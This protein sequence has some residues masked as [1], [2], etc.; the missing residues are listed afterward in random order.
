MGSVFKKLLII[1]TLII[2]FINLSCYQNPKVDYQK[3]KFLLLDDRLIENFKNAKLV[4]GTVKKN[5]ANPLFVEDKPWEKRF[6]NLYGNIIY[7]EDEN[8]YQCWYSP[9]IVDYSA[10]NMTLVERQQ[11]YDSPSDREM[12]ICYAYSKDGINW[13]KPE[14]GLVEFEGTKN[15]NLIG[16]GPHG[17]GVFRD[18]R[19]GDPLKKYKAIFQQFGK[20]TKT[21]HHLKAN[22]NVQ[23]KLKSTGAENSQDLREIDPWLDQTLNLDRG[24]SISTSED[25]I[26]WSKAKRINGVDVAGDTHNNAF[27]APTIG[28]YVGITRSWHRKGEKR[29]W[30]Q[31]ARIESDDFV[32]WTKEEVILEGENIN[33]Q[34]YAMPVFYYAGIYIGLPAIYSSESDRTWTELAWSVDTKNWKR[35]SPGLP[36]IPTSDKVLDYDYGCVYA[37]AT[38]I[39]L[40]NEIRLYYGGSDYLHFGWRNGSL[41][42]A[43]LR[44]DGFAGYEQIIKDQTAKVKTKLMSFDADSILITADISDNGWIKVNIFDKNGEQIATSDK[45]V[46]TI[47][48]GLLRFQK[49]INSDDIQLEFEFNKAKLYSFAFSN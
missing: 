4:V 32:N 35:I 19:E 38:P 8:L 7:N 27:W 48:D 3:N 20:D 41:C 18:L 42:L 5:N 15:N 13:V 37:C 29:I 10:N 9:F 49:N 44:P 11:P 17:T 47:T 39:F 34:M 24:I 21:V 23:K 22:K 12:G 46:K 45:I 14:L 43:T 40:K 1:N 28:K 25:G 16:R 2:V 6:D 36:L 26:N 31:V 33:D 30:R